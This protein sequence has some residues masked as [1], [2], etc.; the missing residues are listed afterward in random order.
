MSKKKRKEKLL[1]MA[2]DN[3]RAIEKVRDK[4]AAQL[5][6][7]PIPIGLGAVIML[8]SGGAANAIG[9]RDATALGIQLVDLLMPAAIEADKAMRQ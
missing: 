9:E 6:E 2:L 3:A 8:L 7:V 5:D 1:E 4:L